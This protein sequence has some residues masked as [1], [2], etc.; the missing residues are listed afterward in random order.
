MAR[1]PGLYHELVLIDQSQRRQRQ[2]E[3]HAAQVQ[4]LTRLLL[5]LVNG[6][7]QIPTSPFTVA[8]VVLHSRPYAIALAA[9]EQARSRRG[10]SCFRYTGPPARRP[11]NGARGGAGRARD[12]PARWRRPVPRRSRIYTAA[13]PSARTD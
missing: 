7:P 8:G 12:L 2:R 13:S 11:N 5:E 3:L 1:Q 6:L 9:Y 4:S 10:L